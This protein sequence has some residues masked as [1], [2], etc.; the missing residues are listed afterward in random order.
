MHNRTKSHQASN[1]NF[2]FSSL[3]PL[4]L[5]SLVWALPGSG[6]NLAESD[7][8]R[9]WCSI[10]TWAQ[11]N[12]IQQDKACSPPGKPG[13]G[14]P[15]V[16]HIGA[17]GGTSGSDWWSRGSSDTIKKYNWSTPGPLAG[18][19]RQI[20]LFLLPCQPLFH[21]SGAHGVHPGFYDFA[22]QSH[23]LNILS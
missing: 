4:S 23:L 1:G 13:P 3:G 22:S 18:G 19:E 15:K 14:P 10:S 6:F 11:T 2:P 9:L 8:F 12:M 21:K 20:T 17:A 16:A 5:A 7:C